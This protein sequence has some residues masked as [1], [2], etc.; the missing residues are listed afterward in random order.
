LTGI[1]VL[2]RLANAARKHLRLVAQYQFDGDTMCGTVAARIQLRNEDCPLKARS[3]NFV[4]SV[5]CGRVGWADD[6]AA[7]CSAWAD[8]LSAGSGEWFAWGW[9]GYTWWIGPAVDPKRTYG[10]AHG[11]SALVDEVDHVAGEQDRS[12]RSPHLDRAEVT[13]DAAQSGRRLR[14][15]LQPRES[16]RTPP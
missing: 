6:E 15:G 7:A 11:R 13:F 10:L 4:R 16:S 5:L 1:H 12:T 8:D 3:R 14:R 9:V 2:T